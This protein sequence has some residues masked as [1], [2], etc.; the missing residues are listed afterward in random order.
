MRLQPKGCSRSWSPTLPPWF[1]ARCRS[2]SPRNRPLHHAQRRGARG[3]SCCRRLDRYPVDM[4]RNDSSVIPAPL[5]FSPPRSWPPPAIRRGSR[6]RRGEVSVRPGGSDTAPAHGPQFRRSP[7][8]GHSAFVNPKLREACHDQEPPQPRRPAL[9]LKPQASVADPIPPRRTSSAATASCAATWSWSRS[10]GAA[11]CARAAPGGGF[12]RCCLRDGRYDGAERAYYF[13]AEGIEGEWGMSLR[14]RPPLPTPDLPTPHLYPLSSTPWPR[15]TSATAA[16][17]T[18]GGDR[19]VTMAAKVCCKSTHKRQLCGSLRIGGEEFKCA[20]RLP[21]FCP[22]S[23][24][25]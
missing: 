17:T 19:R 8:L 12:K 3:G 2:R 13:Q 15:G 9:L 18:H 23:P 7:C 22:R 4:R 14:Q 5:A 21:C 6:R 11:T 10:S 24:S 25:R 16:P 20:P 1:Q